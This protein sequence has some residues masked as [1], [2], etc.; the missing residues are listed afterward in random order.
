MS[1]P[2]KCPGCG[3]AVGSARFFLSN[4]PVVL[5]YR[6]DSPVAA[7]R[8]ARRDMALAQCGECGLVFNSTFDP[9]VIPYDENYENRQCASPTFSE[10]LRV[11]AHDLVDR[12]RLHGGRILEIGCGKGDYLRLIC[13]EAGGTG[14][15]FDT[16]FEGGS[17]WPDEGLRFHR[18]YVSAADVQERFDAMICRHVIEHVPAVGTFLSN[19]SAIT[20]AAGDPIVVVETP[21][22]E[23]IIENGCFWDIFYEHCNYFS[24]PCLAHLAGRAGFEVIKHSLVF[25]RQYQLLELRRGASDR[26]VLNTPS[27]LPGNALGR[28][29]QAFEEARRK[30]E[31][32]LLQA[33]AERGW[34]VWGA[35]AKGV[36]LVNRVSI[37]PPRFV[38][39]SNP[40][41]QGGVIPGSSVQIVPPDHPQ[42]LDIP[43]IL[44]ANPNYYSEIESF[45]AAR[46]FRNTLLTT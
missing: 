29:T 24:L 11:Q 25:G 44:V 35:G 18:R 1:A 19:L 26:P 17:D 32:R 5:N 28:F 34:A 37:Q 10:Y 13:R 23:W 2:H 21:S 14:V 46:G 31:G 9:T 16:T 36:A 40:A 3:R 15:G 45:L 6:F 43:V 38:I 20:T 42:V 39:D 12:H 7:S 41:K 4:E 22:L 27:V 8:V 30:L 33:G